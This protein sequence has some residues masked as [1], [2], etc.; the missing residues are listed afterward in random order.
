MQGFMAS[1][2]GAAV[3][4]LIAALVVTP[5]VMAAAHVSPGAVRID[6]RDL[7]ISAGYTI[8]SVNL[9]IGLSCRPAC[10]AELTD[11]A[12]IPAASYAFLRT[13]VADQAII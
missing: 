11:E 1:K 2:A 4:A 7:L 9:T 6:G 13:A 3:C 10:P 8:R 12:R 5:E